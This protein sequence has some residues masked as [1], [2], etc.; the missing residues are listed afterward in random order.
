VI[1]FMA[2]DVWDDS[3]AYESYVGRWSRLIAAPF[4]AW[5]DLH[6]GGAWL[7]VGCGTGALTREIL[8]RANPR[9]AVGCD[10]SAA[11]IAFASAQTA[12][13]RAR[14]VQAEVSDLP[15][16]EDG[17]DAVVA[18]LLLNFLPS[19]VDG[20]GAMAARARRGGTVAAYVWDYAGQMQ[21]MRYFWDAAVILNPAADE[22][23]EG[24][25]FPICNP[26]RLETLFRDAGLSHV[27]SRGIDV[28]TRFE[29]FDDYWS[30]FLGGQGPAPGYARSLSEVERADLRERIRGAL[31]VQAD[32]SIR[33][34]ARAWAVRGATSA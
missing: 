22:L 26:Q 25:R 9:V 12:D 31:P 29:N 1:S 20:L 32:G 28:P 2:T 18:G 8:G 13:A 4:I 19:P 5:L 21:L 7:D 30:P 14:F 27:E 17:F 11:Y 33:L 34:I 6:G 23:D 3:A 15:Q 24:R 16:T 10:R